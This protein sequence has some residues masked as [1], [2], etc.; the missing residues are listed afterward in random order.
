MGVKQALIQQIVATFNEAYLVD[1]NNQTANSINDNVSDVLT[2]LQENYGKLMPHELLER[3]NVV[4][5]TT[6]HPQDPISIA[7]S[8][9]VELLEFYDI[10]RNS[11]TQH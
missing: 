8:A 2:N 10:T 9:I 6:Y 1:I 5:K 7:I 11:Y 4:K 3:E